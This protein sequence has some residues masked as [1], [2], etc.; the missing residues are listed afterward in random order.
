MDCHS[1]G[2]LRVLL[3]LIVA[4]DCERR[5]ISEIAE[6]LS[7]PLNN[8]RQPQSI[9]RGRPRTNT[10]SSRPQIQADSSRRGSFEGPSRTQHLNLQN[11]LPQRPQFSQAGSPYDAHGP[12]CVDPRY[13]EL[14][15]ESQKLENTPV[16]GLVKPFPRV[17]RPGIEERSA[18]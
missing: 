7:R 8:R 15:P 1:K 14:N 10:N 2:T 5:G 3:Y 16:W 4:L 12:S 6:K 9:N 13:L 17:V 11:A 18:R